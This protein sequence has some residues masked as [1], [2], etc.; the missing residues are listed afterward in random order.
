M[1]GAFWAQ[2]LRESLDP[3][4]A[5]IVP[6]GFKERSD[7]S[8]LTSRIGIWIGED[9]EDRFHQRPTILGGHLPATTNGMREEMKV[10]QTLRP[11]RT[12]A[13]HPGLIYRNH[14]APG[15]GGRLAGKAPRPAGVLV[16]VVVVT[17]PLYSPHP[18]RLQRKGEV[19]QTR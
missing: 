9:L 19:R 12:T 14:Q 11:T 10:K 6:V 4:K 17:F 13:P 1:L 8:K 7:G 16:S 2:S 15:W 3:T 5:K 18:R